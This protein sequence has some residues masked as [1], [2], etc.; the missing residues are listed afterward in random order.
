[1]FYLNMEFSLMTS[2]IGYDE[3]NYAHIVNFS[4]RLFFLLISVCLN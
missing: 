2:Q 3:Y 1:M 4:P